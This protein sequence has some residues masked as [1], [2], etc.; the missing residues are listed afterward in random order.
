MLSF[1]QWQRKLRE[2]APPRSGKASATNPPK[3]RSGFQAVQVTSSRPLGVSGPALPVC[4][5]GGIEVQIADNLPAI[6]AVMRAVGSGASA[7]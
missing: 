1:Y 7:C 3:R 5:P 4:L 2:L 6:Q